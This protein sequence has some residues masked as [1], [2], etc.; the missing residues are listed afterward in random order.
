M[1]RDFNFFL[2]RVILCNDILAEGLGVIHTTVHIN[3]SRKSSFYKTLLKSEEFENADSPEALLFRVEGNFLKSGV[4]WKLKF[5]DR[6]SNSSQT[7]IKRKIQ[8]DWWLLGRGVDD[9]K[10]RDFDSFSECQHRFQMSLVQSGRGLIINTT[11]L[12]KPSVVAE[13]T[14]SEKISTEE[15]N[16]GKIIFS[17]TLF[18]V[19]L[20]DLEVLNP[21]LAVQIWA[22]T[23]IKNTSLFSHVFYQFPSRP[24]G[25]L[26]FTHYCSLFH[27]KY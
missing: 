20:S 9:W 16:W 21:A 25:R 8:N 17:S 27:L 24:H 11:S 19:N 13:N 12:R 26:R 22:L 10:P 1:I 4:F 3:P 2:C 14:C 15:Q 18:Y 23:S 5:S 6:V 7:Q